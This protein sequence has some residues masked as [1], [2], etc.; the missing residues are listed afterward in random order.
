MVCVIVLSNPV[1]V[2]SNS[3]EPS[4]KLSGVAPYSGL[5]SSIACMAM[6]DSAKIGVCARDS[7]RS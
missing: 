4:R 3:A 2:T 6:N 7:L 5:A 1:T